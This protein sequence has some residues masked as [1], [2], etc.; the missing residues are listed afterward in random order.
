MLLAAGEFTE[1]MLLEAEEF[2][3]EMLLEAEEFTE[4]ML[5]EVPFPRLLLSHSPIATAVFTGTAIFAGNQVIT[6]SAFPPNHFNANIFILIVY[7][8]FCSPF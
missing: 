8:I 1:E 5:L 3:V 2:T 7:N 6:I 4:E